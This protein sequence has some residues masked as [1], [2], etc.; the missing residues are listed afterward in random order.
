MTIAEAAMSENPGIAQQVPSS[1]TVPRHLVLCPAA[2]I[3]N[4]VDELKMWIPPHTRILGPIYP[5]TARVPD[6][7]RVATI[8]KWFETK[9]ILILSYDMFRALVKPKTSSRKSSAESDVD[10]IDLDPMER[11]EIRRKLL[12]GPSIVV[13]DEAHKIKNKKSVVGALVHDFS[14]KSRIALTGSPLANSLQDYYAMID[15]ISPGYLGDEKEF[16]AKYKEPIEAG[17]HAD[18]TRYEQRRSLKKLK[19]LKAEIEPKV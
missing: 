5:I 6:A 2:L 11:T 1:M 12:T 3:D 9:G 10:E 19:A 8:K 16:R 15:W 13:A 14:T 4:W 7:D 18:S 17:V